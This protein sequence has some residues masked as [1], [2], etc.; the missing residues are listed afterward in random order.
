MNI[1]K[2]MT[3][4]LPASAAVAAGVAFSAPS[5]AQASDTWRFERARGGGYA[6]SCDSF[7]GDR[8]CAVV[9]CGRDTDGL[10]IGLVG[11]EPR[12][13]GDRRDGRI[14]IDGRTSNVTYV[15]ET[16]PVVGEVW[17]A[18]VNDRRAE[19]LANRIQAGSRL[20]M[21][22]A[23]RGPAYDFTLR[24]SSAAISQLENR[25]ARVDNRDD[26]R[27]NRV[28]AIDDALDGATIRLGDENFG[29]AIRLGDGPAVRPAQNRDWVQ[30]ASNRVDR[31]RDR[32]VIE[33]DRRDGRFDAIRL[34]VRGNDVRIRQVR[35]RYGN[36]QT[37]RLDV[38]RRIGEGDSSGV[39]E[40]RG[41][42]GRYI[43]RIVL[44]YDTQGRGRRAEV[45]V[46]GHRAN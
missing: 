41:R 13:R 23:A 24:G 39:L 17:R 28:E 25:C 22:I 7:G 15:R 5:S 11:W 46:W 9:Y 26:R 6:Q 30:L 42:Q 37:E 36:G 12:G 44:I 27:S 21:D 3:R 43:D 31:Q 34:R 40:L 18:N 29:I 38:N 19:R 20:S 8:V 33:L 10:E 4:I 14:A 32:D 2:L 1:S 35:V 45:E 16:D